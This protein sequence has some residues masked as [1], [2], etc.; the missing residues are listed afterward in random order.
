MISSLFA[1]GFTDQPNAILSKPAENRFA[2]VR[3]FSTSSM[4]GAQHTADTIRWWDFVES[5]GSLDSLWPF[6]SWTKIWRLSCGIAIN[7]KIISKMSI[8]FR[9]SKKLKTNNKWPEKL[10]QQFY[11]PV[12]EI[13]SRLTADWVWILATGARI[14]L[15]SQTLTERSSDPDTIWS[16][17]LKA[18]QVT[19]SVWPYKKTKCGLNIIQK[20]STSNL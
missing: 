13:S 1:V 15:R 6:K 14:F 18:A 7:P 11:L 20:I 4:S 9:F 17:R 2:L 19:D 16:V 12:E 3:Q 10:F 5:L 8:Q